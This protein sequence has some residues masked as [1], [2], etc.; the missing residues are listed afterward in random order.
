M[1]QSKSY[2][3]DEMIET[4]KHYDSYYK[5]QRTKRGLYILST[6]INGFVNWNDL[7][8]PNQYLLYLVAVQNL[9][10]VKNQ[11]DYL[12]IT[13]LHNHMENDIHLFQTVKL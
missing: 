2:N 11:K 13:D 4:I 1:A 9:T 7:E 8:N 3:R 6:A 12:M 5:K 10:L